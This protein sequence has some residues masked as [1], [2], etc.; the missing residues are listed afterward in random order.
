LAAFVNL[1]I[2]G[3]R[4][5]DEFDQAVRNEDP[6][7]LYA[8]DYK[9]PNKINRLYAL[10]LTIGLRY[11]ILEDVLFENLRPYLNA[12]IGPTMLVSLPYDIEF[13]KSF[14]HAS[15]YLTGGGFVG[16]GADFGG[17]KPSL[18]FNA[19]Y[20]YIPYGPGLE[21]LKDEKI[22]DFGGLFLTMTLG[23]GH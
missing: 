17:K 4:K 3:A 12:G 22:T 11:R 1:D 5:S 18:G 7:A 9:V 21:S 14:G 8:Y 20:Y 15:A 23:F 19:R 10:P 6:D 16:I 2:S 13:F